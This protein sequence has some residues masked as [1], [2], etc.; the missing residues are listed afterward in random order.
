LKGLNYASQTFTL[1]KPLTLHALDSATSVTGVFAGLLHCRQAYFERQRAQEAKRVLS[2]VKAEIQPA[3]ESASTRE[4]LRTL[5]AA[6]RGKKYAGERG[7]SSEFVD[8]LSERSPLATDQLRAL[9][10]LMDAVHTTMV[11]T[12]DDALLAADALERHSK[13]RRAYG[14]GSAILAAVLAALPWFTKEDDPQAELAK[15]VLTATFATSALGWIAY[16]ARQVWVGA[17]AQASTLSESPSAHDVEAIRTW[18]DTPVQALEQDFDQHAASSRFFVSTLLV[19]YLA[20]APKREAHGER[21]ATADEAGNVV[22]T[23]F[24]IRLLGFLLGKTPS[25][26]RALRIEAR[27]ADPAVKVMA[28]AVVARSLLGQASVERRFARSHPGAVRPGVQAP[29]NAAP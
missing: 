3:P 22:R 7:P 29:L 26:I 8:L 15:D 12:T 27:S 25:A 9:D 23:K 2:A 16:C 11:K 19:R 14:A 24:A 1:A 17:R 13:R 6:Y 21:A 28:V 4:K 10:K 18:L 5:D 20:L